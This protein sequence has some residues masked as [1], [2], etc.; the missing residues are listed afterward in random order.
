MTV[1]QVVGLRF[2]CDDESVALAQK[3]AASGLSETDIKKGCGEQAYRPV[4]DCALDAESALG[5][6]TFRRSAC[7]GGGKAA[8]RKLLRFE[9]LE[10][11]EQMR[12]DYSLF[13]AARQGAAA[14]IT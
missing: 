13:E 10:N 12:D 14:A 1:R 2:A 9:R 5:E 3:A 7:Q 4:P 11:R 6:A 8:N